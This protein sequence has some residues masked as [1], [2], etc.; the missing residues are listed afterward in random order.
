MDKSWDLVV[1]SQDRRSLVTQSEARVD[2]AVCRAL[3]SQKSPTV[4]TIDPMQF[5]KA[6]KHTDILQNPMKIGRD[7]SKST[8][9]T[10]SDLEIGIGDAGLT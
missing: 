10:I 9:S 7:G 1:R 4:P 6:S 5:Q 3:I 2:E 8:L